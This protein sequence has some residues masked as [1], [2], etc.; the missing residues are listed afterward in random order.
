MIRRRQTLI[1]A[2]TRRTESRPSQGPAHEL[3]PRVLFLVGLAFGPEAGSGAVFAA[4][5]DVYLDG[6][7]HGRTARFC[8]FFGASHLVQPLL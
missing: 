7:T 4:R 6:D 5:Q 3:A 1:L 2:E 8:R